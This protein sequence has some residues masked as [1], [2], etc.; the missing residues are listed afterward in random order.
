ML[1]LKGKT[2]MGITIEQNVIE[3]LPTGQYPARISS[4]DQVSG[5]FGDQ[6]KIKFDLAPNAEGEKQS[7][8]GWA[9]MKFNPKSKLYSWV[10]S[11]LGG[12]PIERSYNFNSDDILGKPVTL[13]V[14]VK[15]N[16]NGEFNKIE[17]VLPYKKTA[18][19]VPQPAAPTDPSEDIPW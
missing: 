3:V 2:E 19:P 7:L 16:E 5:Q 14:V 4:I 9:S 12:S 13:V 10:Q 15:S 11:A 6:L 8:L 17:S 18:K 1:T